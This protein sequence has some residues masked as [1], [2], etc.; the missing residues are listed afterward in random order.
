MG[1]VLFEKS[2]LP[3]PLTQNFFDVVFLLSCHVV[4]CSQRT[5]KLPEKLTGT[6]RR[7]RLKSFCPSFFRT[8][9]FNER[10]GAP[11]NFKSGYTLIRVHL[12]SFAGCRGGVLAKTAF[13]FVCFLFSILLQN[14]KVCDK[15]K[16][17]QRR[18]NYEFIYQATCFFVE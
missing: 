6:T 11:K 16:K 2:T 12:K 14:V 15:I 7:A 1:R 9:Q 10:K 8:F 13:P 3:T 18:D 4:G 17:T 5:A